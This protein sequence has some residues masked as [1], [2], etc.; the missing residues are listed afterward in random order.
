MEMKQYKNIKDHNRRVYAAMVSCMDEAV[1]NVTR[2][3]KKRG[4]WEDTVLIFSS[5]NG[6]NGGGKQLAAARLESF[7]VGRRHKRRRVCKQ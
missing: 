5:D 6:G 3:L 4:L 2:V 1:G 7:A